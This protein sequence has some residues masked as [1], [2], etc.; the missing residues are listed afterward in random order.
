MD[1]KTR[2]FID[3][4]KIVHG[5]K[6]GYD[7]VVYKKSSEKVKIFCK[8]HE[9]LFEQSPNKHLMNRGC[10][11][12]GQIRSND[13]NR[14]DIHEFIKKSREIHKNKY[15]YDS[16]DYIDSK[17]KVKIY[18]KT[19]N[20]Y[21]MQIP[22]SHIAGK[23]CKKCGYDSSKNIHSYSLDEFVNM[24]KALYKD[25]FS[26]ELA[27]YNGYNNKIYLTCEI[28][29]R[30]ETT[31]YL[32]L[33]TRKNAK[34]AN[35]G[36]Q[37]CNMDVVYFNNNKGKHRFIEDSIEIHGDKF[38]YDNVNYIDNKTPVEILCEK[39]HVMNQI[40]SNHLRG[41]GCYICSLDINTSE[42][43]KEIL[44]YIKSIT[45]L[46][47]LSN[48]R[49]IINPYELDVF[50]PTLNLAIEFNGLHW[51]SEKNKDKN[52]HVIKNKLCK[53]MDVRLVQIWE[54]EWLEKQEL[55]KSFLKSLIIQ[56]IRSHARKF[57]VKHVPIEQQVEFLNKYHF[58]GY[59]SAS[60]VF[61]LYNDNN[62]LMQL[63]SFKKLNQ[64]GD[65][66]IGR[67]CTKSGHAVVGGAERLF[68]RLIDENKPKSVISYNNLDK[69][70]GEVYT[71]LGLY[72]EKEQIYSYFYQKGQKAFPRQQFQKHKLIEQGH[73]P[74]LTEV[75]IANSMGY[76]RVFPTGNSKYR[77]DFRK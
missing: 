42:S 3:K 61:G 39:G 31:P 2:E 26:Y 33:D 32:H 66:E 76:Y 49:D 10:P 44:E 34:N 67:L 47:V 50:I 11:K 4:A 45:N 71:R 77:I 13:Y 19:H 70:T 24:S 15:S 14:S 72:T 63:M 54:H 36:C 12:C 48:N 40:P 20:E 64:I 27:K 28:H 73:D 75:E 58:Q 68:K 51:H 37:K 60:S 30:I 57:H 56:P 29:G 23:G 21:F 52:Y 1:D 9:Y 5:D 18:C 53:D 69:F 59:S 17:T 7:E 43:E 55:C 35:L 46:E 65:Y 62:E 16:V 6:Y 74:N 8:I 41:K 25:K 38:S 22:N